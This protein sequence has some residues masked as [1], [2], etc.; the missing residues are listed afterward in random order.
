M[1][2]RRSLLLAAIALGIVTIVKALQVSLTPE[3]WVVLTV[4][5][6]RLLESSGFGFLAALTGI[7]FL[8]SLSA[9][10]WHRAERRYER[11]D[12]A[13]A[14]ARADLAAKGFTVV[15]SHVDTSSLLDDSQRGPLPESWRAP[16]G[17]LVHLHSNPS[18]RGQ[19]APRDAA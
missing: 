2:A 14:R 4:A 15:P 5:G 18:D 3:A 7:A 1:S 11:E 8:G 13:R 12:E 19:S 16:C 6:R 10:A 17:E 9:A